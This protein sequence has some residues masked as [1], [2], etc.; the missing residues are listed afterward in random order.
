MIIE[1]DF[2][3]KNK[4]GIHVRPAAML[5]QVANKFKSEVYLCKDK[6]TVNGK[7]IMGILTLA[8]GQGSKLSIRIEG[9]DA[10]E[11]LKQLEKLFENKFD[12]E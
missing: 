2:I 1:K 9:S 8:A 6:Q 3:L 4:L 11:M 12:E 10:E 5:V 7:S